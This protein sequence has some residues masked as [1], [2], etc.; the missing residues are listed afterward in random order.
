M[1]IELIIC[2]YVEVISET[3]LQVGFH[4]IELFYWNLLAFFQVFMIVV[5]YQ[6]HL[7]VIFD[8]IKVVLN[9]LCHFKISHKLL[10]LWWNNRENQSSNENGGEKY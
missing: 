1:L 10:Q 9:V 5:V 7:K 2:N 8:R 3:D 6:E 4:N